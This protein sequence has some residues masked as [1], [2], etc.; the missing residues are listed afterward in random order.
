MAAVPTD[1][2]VC[3]QKD[4]QKATMARA[5]GTSI[6]STSGAVVGLTGTG[7]IGSA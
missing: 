4:F 5:L 6:G 2:P 1:C 3:H 7:N